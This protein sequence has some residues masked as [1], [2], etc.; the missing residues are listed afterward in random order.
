MADWLWN[1]AARAVNRWQ[2]D[3]KRTGSHGPWFLWYRRGELQ[4]SE[5]KP[6]GFELGDS[7]RVPSRDAQ[8]VLF[9]VM[10]RARRLPCL[11]ME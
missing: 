2:A 6:E 9:W 8:G 7:E 3:W 5:E 10:E 4:L 1:E 11:P